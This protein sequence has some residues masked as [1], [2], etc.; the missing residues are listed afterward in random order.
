M[1]SLRARILLWIIIAFSTTLLGLCV[2][3]YLT[4]KQNLYKE[5]DRIITDKVSLISSAIY[6]NK[7]N[8]TAQI[9]QD[10][11]PDQDHLFIQITDLKGNIIGKS[12]NLPEPLPLTANIRTQVLAREETALDI[13]YNKKGETIRIATYPRWDDKGIIGFAQVGLNLTESNRTLQ[14]LRLWLLAATLLALVIV[15]SVSYLLIG[16]LLKPLETIIQTANKI[17]RE[18]LAKQRLVIEN[19]KDEPGRLA[20]TFNEMLDRLDKAFALQQRFVADAAH[21]LRTPLT[22]LRGEIEVLLRRSRTVDEYQEVL[23]SNLEEIE[24]LS[25]L[26]SNLLTLARVDAGEEIIAVQI[27]DLTAL[28]QDVCKKLAA[29]MAQKNIDF[30]LNCSQEI[31]ILGDSAGLERVVYNLVE[32]AIKYSP[33]GETIK[34]SLQKVKAQI[35]LIVADT[36]IGISTEDLPNIFERFYRADK[37][38]S[39]ES[40]GSGLGLAIVET[41]VKAHKGEIT[42]SS[43]LGK[44]TTFTI[45]LP[46]IS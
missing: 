44:G 14:Q 39:R 9:E 11:H 19:P 40:G 6:T 43:Q 23:K 22:A 20:Q 32:N 16:R 25:L 2:S 34:V 5:R 15:I 28:C 30:Q 21:E 4:I 27:C 10:F 45:L 38:R 17:S 46:D 42:V 35:E 7:G 31:K 24:R 1:R 12:L 13:G 37:A 29:L 3:F 18:N 41:I 8:I 26:T 36:G 33:P